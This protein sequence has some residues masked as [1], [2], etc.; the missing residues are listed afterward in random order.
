MIES[1]EKAERANQLK[2][3]F[4]A[5]MSHEIR[6]PINVI[7]SFLGLINEEDC[8]KKNDTVQLALNSIHS[9]S[10]RITRTIDMILNM[11]E[12][13]IGS[14]ET[15]FSEF[16]IYDTLLAH[17]LNEFRQPANTKNILLN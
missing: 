17:L 12:L 2:S 6:T 8:T 4:L 11:S 15:I 5:Q 13:Q 7:V 3:E 14:Y 9:S 1:K 16:D 10:N